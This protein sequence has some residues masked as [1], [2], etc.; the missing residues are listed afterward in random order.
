MGQ[1][2]S[3]DNE[4]SV[5]KKLV[6]HLH[7]NWYVCL[8]RLTPCT[9]WIFC[10]LFYIICFL[11]P[12]H[13]REEWRHMKSGLPLMLSIIFYLPLMR[14]SLT[15][16]HIYLHSSHHACVYIIRAPRLYICILSV[17][18]RCESKICPSFSRR[19]VSQIERI[20]ARPKTHTHSLCE[21]IVFLCVSA[22]QPAVGPRFGA[23]HFAVIASF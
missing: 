3:N 9:C 17:H 8:E 19:R 18:G 21:Y 12:T 6:F 2:S 22:R 23:R 16:R 10:H 5:H 11:P 4:Q 1:K 15:V 14:L 7:Y 20:S 13:T